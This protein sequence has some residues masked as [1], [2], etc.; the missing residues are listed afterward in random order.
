[1]RRFAT[2]CIVP[3]GL[4]AST[5]QPALS[6]CYGAARMSLKGRDES[7]EAIPSASGSSRPKAVDPVLWSHFR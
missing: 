2:E 3:G 6:D 4:V 1:M 7:V 5:D